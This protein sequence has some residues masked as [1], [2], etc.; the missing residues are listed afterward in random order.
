MQLVGER[1][2]D[3]E[4]FAFPVINCGSG[5]TILHNEGSQL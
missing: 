5:A 2:C 3:A 1:F 4:V